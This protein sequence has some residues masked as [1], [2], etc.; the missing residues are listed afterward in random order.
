MMDAASIFFEL[1]Q[2]SFWRKGFATEARATEVSKY[3]SEPPW[4]CGQS[5]KRI[6][7]RSR[8]GWLSEPE[9]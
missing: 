1:D 7:K 9:P 8:T 4:L 6:E 5:V 2:I 3:F